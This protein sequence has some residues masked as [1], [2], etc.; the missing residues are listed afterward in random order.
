MSISPTHV[1]RP[2]LSSQHVCGRVIRHL[3][4]GFPRDVEEMDAI[5][6]A[7]L[8][9]S[10]NFVNTFHDARDF[11]VRS[12]FRLEAKYAL[13]RQRKKRVLKAVGGAGLKLAADHDLGKLVFAKTDCPSAY[14]E[15][16][17]LPL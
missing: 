1:H 14:E 13:G 10:V 16:A 7:N 11:V 5:T 15:G 3:Q 8:R 2:K 12:A 17:L 4:D 6:A 9:L